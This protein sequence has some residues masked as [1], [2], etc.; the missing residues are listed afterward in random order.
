[1]AAHIAHHGDKGHNYA[2]LWKW[3]RERGIQHRN[4]RKGM[5]S[6]EWLDSHR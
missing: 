2:Y 4:A 6:S 1:M 3:L 5:E